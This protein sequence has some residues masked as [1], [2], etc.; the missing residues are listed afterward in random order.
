MKYEKEIP[1]QEA[2]LTKDLFLSSNTQDLTE[3]SSSQPTEEG[4]RL[5]VNL[6]EQLLSKTG[7][8]EAGYSFSSA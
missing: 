6:E 3:N 7:L 1:R 2:F 4:I 8:R 5:P